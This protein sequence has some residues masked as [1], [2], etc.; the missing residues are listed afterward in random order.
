MLENFVVQQHKN[1][2]SGGLRLVGRAL[3][4]DF[5]L[6]GDSF[7]INSLMSEVFA[8]D[9]TRIQIVFT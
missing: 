8:G 9:F 4:K 3:V 2:K 1:S 7:E 5:S 6:G